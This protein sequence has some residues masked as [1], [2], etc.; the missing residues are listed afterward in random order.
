[1]TRIS[2]IKGLMELTQ[3]IREMREAT[4]K[5]ACKYREGTATNAEL[6][7]HLTRLGTLYALIDLDTVDENAV[8]SNGLKGKG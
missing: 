7:D 5:I 6:I 8:E 3:S 1:M 4:D 2:T